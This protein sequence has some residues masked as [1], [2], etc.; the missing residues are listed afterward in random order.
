MGS[1]HKKPVEPIEPP[2]SAPVANPL[3]I[4]V[5]PI[6]RHERQYEWGAF[7]SGVRIR[8]ITPPEGSIHEH[9]WLPVQHLS[10]TDQP[11]FG[12][13]LRHNGHLLV[14]TTNEFTIKTQD[15]ILH[16]VKHPWISPYHQVV[17][18]E[19][20]NGEISVHDSTRSWL[21]IPRT[22]QLWTF[23]NPVGSL[24]VRVWS[25]QQPKTA[26]L[27]ALQVTGLLADLFLIIAGYL[28]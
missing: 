19:L 28:P 6:S 15:R 9:T 10:V 4:V 23:P 14:I 5:Y 1:V 25:C 3:C 11:K 16:S 17:A 20:P 7:G 2:Y 21:W 24:M 22:G 26:L 13:P 18:G 27:T 12:L 8:G